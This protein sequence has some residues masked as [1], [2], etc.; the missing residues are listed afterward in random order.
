MALLEDSSL[1]SSTRSSKLRDVGR[2]EKQYSLSFR[3]VIIFEAFSLQGWVKGLKRPHGCEE[4]PP[5]VL[6]VC[7]LSPGCGC[8]AGMQSG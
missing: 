5:A 3:D 8:S 1:I 7:S 6:P 2:S 4:V